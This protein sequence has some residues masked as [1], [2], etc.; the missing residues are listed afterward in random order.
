M[1]ENYQEE[2]ELEEEIQEPE[3][4]HFATVAGVY[5]D[6]LTLK[7][8]GAAAASSKRY[9]CN[10]FFKFAVGDR[11]FIM[12]DS[13]T[14]VVICKIGAPA[15]SI[16]VDYA[17]SA[18]TANS[19]TTAN[20]ASSATS[21]NSASSATNVTTY[22][23]G[24]AI[25]TI[26]ESNGTTV[27]NATSASSASTATSASSATNASNVTSQINGK[28]ITNIFESDGTTA[29]TATNYTGKH[30]GSSIAFFN[31]MSR[32]KSTITRLNTSATLT[33]V[34]NKLNELLNALGSTGYNLI[35]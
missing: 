13:G 22:I 17:A 10:T 6:G 24:K 5:S 12:K 3:D 23:N 35:N 28:L 16:N 29:K 26:F 32:T 34:I 4:Q 8:D 2:K 1:I 31:G 15:T 14:Y 27:K 20:T 25:S 18:N 11:V 7:F 19:A 9:K 30:T 21:A 33:D